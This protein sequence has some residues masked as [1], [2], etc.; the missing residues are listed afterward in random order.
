MLRAA[1]APPPDVRHIFDS[2]L[3]SGRDFRLVVSDRVRVPMCCGLWRPTVV[4]PTHL[5][6]TAGVPTLRWVFAHEL[7]HLQRR[8][9]WSCCLLGL[10]QSVYFYVPWFWWLRRQ[11]RLCQEFVADA[12][13]VAQGSWADDYAQFL[14]SLARCPAAPRGATGVLGNRSDLYRRV[15]M[16]LNPAESPRRAWSR[17]RILTVALSLA[18]VAAIGSGVGLRTARADDKT[19]ETPAIETFVFVATD[20]DQDSVIK[21]LKAKRDELVAKHGADHPDVK[22]IEMKLEAVQMA[23]RAAKEGKADAEK[24]QA[25]VVWVGDEHGGGDVLK[26]LNHEELEK[27]VR[28]A[29]EK[30]K[31]SDEQV[32]QVLEEL[33]K[34]HKEQLKVFSKGMP[35]MAGA[36]AGN[37]VEGPLMMKLQ[38]VGGGGRLGVEVDPVGQVLADQL[39]LSQGQGLVIRKVRSGS[40]AE[41][42]G[43]KANDILMVLNGQNVSNDVARSGQVAGRRQF[44]QGDRCCCDP[45]GSE[46]DHLRNQ[47]CETG[48]GACIV[49]RRTQTRDGTGSEGPP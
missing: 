37:A 34:V 14:V 23:L 30:A 7:M 6:Q 43:V 25:K 44:R 38:R 19:P 20:D 17:G 49:E 22:K 4:I 46:A 28:E 1:N 12:A 2:L 47:T 36:F 48:R 35:G 31:L 32:K 26:S 39:G 8:D 3:P 18:A 15:N 24:F 27:K 42:A 41:K 40:S 45:Q 13:A 21:D 11:V 29:L 5:V 33:K 10:A 9:P 16:V